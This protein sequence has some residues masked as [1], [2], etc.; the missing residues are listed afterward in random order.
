MSVSIH[1]SVESLLVI[2]S[3]AG[4]L[5]EQLSLAL[6]DS[7]IQAVQLK[8]PPVIYYT[9][10]TCRYRERPQIKTKKLT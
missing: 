2:L 4:H 6:R 10:W 3:W 9:L 5:S 1:L 8:P 7:R